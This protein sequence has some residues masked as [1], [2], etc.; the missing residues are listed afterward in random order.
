MKAINFMIDYICKYQNNYVSSYLFRHN[1]PV[2]MEKGISINN[3]ICNTSNIFKMPFDF[4]EWPSNHT[5]N[6]YQIRPYN[7]NFFSIRNHY[8]DVFVG[9]EFEPI[10]GKDIGNAPVYKIKYSINL[11]PIIGEHCMLNEDDEDEG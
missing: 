1:L 7:F 2:M 10:E 5:D 9:E 8:K 11:L 4:D 3:L 6:S